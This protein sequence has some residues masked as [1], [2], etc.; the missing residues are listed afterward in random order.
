MKIIDKVALVETD[1]GKML[2]TRSRGKT[3]YYAPG[4][5]REAGET[6]YETLSREIKEELNVDILSDNA[7][8][9]G[10]FKAQADGHAAGVVVR[11][12]CY[13]ADYSGV[14]KASGEIEAISWLSSADVDL[15]AEVDRQVFA[16]LKEQNK[17]S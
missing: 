13:E 4:G 15:V 9:L 1:A 8:Y 14:P 17:L 5:K 6:D 10:T 11:M 16:F 2:I 12:T 3:K 7:R